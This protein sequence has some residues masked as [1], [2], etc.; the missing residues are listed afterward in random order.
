MRVPSGQWRE[1]GSRGGRR[2]GGGT[3]GGTDPEAK[4]LLAARPSC[5]P[6]QKEKHPP[7]LLPPSASVA[8]AAIFGFPSTA[9]ADAGIYGLTAPTADGGKV[10]LSKYKGKVM[11]VVNVASACE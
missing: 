3:R 9:S 11:L 2:A 6:N 1:E 10:N 7:P 4:Q 5:C 8:A